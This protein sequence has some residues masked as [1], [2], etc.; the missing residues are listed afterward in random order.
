MFKYCVWYTFKKSSFNNV[1]LRNASLFNT[2]KYPAHITIKSG[3]SDLNEANMIA[4]RY[5]SI[6][7]TFVPYGKPKQTHVKLMHGIKLIDFYAIEQLL[8]VNGH[9][10][11]VHISLAYKNEPFTDMEL[12]VA[13]A[14]IPNIIYPNDLHI[15]VMN[16]FCDRPEGWFIAKTLV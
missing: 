10:T 3:I 2:Y 5:R 1:I 9:N 8:M 11:D 16:C 12:A 4:D 13:N 15:C 14:N 7:P 6:H